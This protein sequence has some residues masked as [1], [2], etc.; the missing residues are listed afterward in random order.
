MLVELLKGLDMDVDKSST[1]VYKWERGKSCGRLYKPIT[2]AWKGDV[3]YS[4]ILP[5]LSIPGIP[6]ILLSSGYWFCCQGHPLRPECTDQLRYRINRTFL[7]TL[8]A[9]RHEKNQTKTTLNHIRCKRHK[10]AFLGHRDF[11]GTTLSFLSLYV[12]FL[13]YISV[14][15]TSHVCHKTMFRYKSTCGK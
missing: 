7:F 4:H 15:P 9:S 3:L 8:Q 5:Q 13:S 11:G 14:F 10:T 2:T 1:Y 6:E 12:I